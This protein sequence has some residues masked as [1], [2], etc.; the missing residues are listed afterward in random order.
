MYV[1]PPVPRCSDWASSSLISPSRISLPR[2]CSRVGLH[3]DLFEDCSAFTRVA[4]RTLARSPICDQLHRRLQPFRHLHDCS[5]CFRLERLPGG[6]RT[7]WKAPPCHGAHVK[8]SSRIAKVDATVG[9]TPALQRAPLPARGFLL[10]RLSNAGPGPRTTVLQGAGVRNPSPKRKSERRP[11]ALSVDKQRDAASR[12]GADR[13]HSLGLW[14]PAAFAEK[15]RQRLQR[16]PDLP[17][18]RI[19][20]KHP[21]ERRRRPIVE[22]GDKA[23]RGEVRSHVVE[24]SLKQPHA[25][26]RRPD[27]EPAIIDSQPSLR[28]NLHSPA[29]HLKAP[30]NESAARQANTDTIVPRQVLWRLGFAAARKI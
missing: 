4:A 14:A 8:R 12:F 20:E 26:D 30:G 11:F 24:R 27:S 29:F 18:A 13:T 6:A 9:R 7:H 28:V 10:G 2:N 5:G 17:S 23:P 25:F 1:L 15:I 3:I 21:V 19:V 22:D 16:G